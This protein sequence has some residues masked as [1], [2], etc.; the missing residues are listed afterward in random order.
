MGIQ[1]RDGVGGYRGNESLDAMQRAGAS[2]AQELGA[3]KASSQKAFMES[4]EEMT[5]PFAAKFVTKQRPIENRT[6]TEK[7]KQADGERQLRPVEA[8]KDSAA[9][10]QQQSKGE[11]DAKMLLLLREYIKSSDS[12]KQILDKL[13]EIF[14]GKD[15]AL[16]DE[17]LDFLIENTDGELQ[18]KVR[19]AQAELR[20]EFKR[21]IAAGRNVAGPA[22]DAAA[23]GL[24]TAAGM[25]DLYRD[26]TG[27]PRD[28]NTL[29]DEL[30]NKWPYDELKNVIG[31]L[32]TSLGSDLRSKGPSIS[33][34]LLHNLLTEARTL[35]AIL[36]VYSFF[37]GRMSLMGKMFQ[38]QGMS[39]PANLTFEGLSKQFMTLV[40]D[41]YPSEEKVLQSAQR[42]GIDKWLRAKIIVL[43]QLRDAIREVAKERIYRSIQDRDKLYDAII[44]TLENLEDE[45]Q[46]LEQQEEE[47]LVSSPELTVS[48]NKLQAHA[49]EMVTFTAE[50][51]EGT[52][53]FTIYW[54]WAQDRGWK[55]AE[56]PYT[57]SVPTT[58]TG[59]IP[60]MVMVR[61]ANEMGSKTVILQIKI[62]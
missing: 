50:I 20:A 60:M 54:Q 18:S 52:K 43:S 57:V 42:L 23:Q 6:K 33:R 51:A 29:F 7:M 44:I 16:M 36:G 25:R 58:A 2:T 35:Q 34:G 24:G 39:M 41:R 21:E 5:N 62:V 28:V 32:L 46:E 11:L 38:S 48:A 49:G 19:E 37:K 9:K 56:S 27:N 22:R 10:F 13:K 4:M 17:A 26:I 14:V 15:V 61:D 47:G 59:Q 3:E 30:A 1:G 53:P 8:I 55:I 12:P 45:L 31:F 40:G